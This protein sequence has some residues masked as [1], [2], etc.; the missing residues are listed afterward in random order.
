MNFSHLE[1]MSGSR[2]RRDKK[3]PPRWYLRCIIG[4]ERFSVDGLFTNVKVITHNRIARVLDITFKDLDRVAIKVASVDFPYKYSITIDG[5]DIHAV[6]IHMN[7][8]KI[9]RCR[10]SDAAGGDNAAT[11]FYEQLRDAM[12]LPLI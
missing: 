4:N 2:V 6:E 8:G 11:K 5:E 10:F 1:R 9:V 12:N 3:Y 7:N